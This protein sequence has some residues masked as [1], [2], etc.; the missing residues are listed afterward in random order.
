MQ[1][2]TFDQV[3]PTADGQITAQD[4]QAFTNYVLATRLGTTLSLLSCRFGGKFPNLIQTK[5]KRKTC[6]M[7]ACRTGVT[8]ICVPPGNECPRTHFPSDI[9][10][11]KQISLPYLAT[12]T[13][14][15]IFMFPRVIK[16][17]P[18]KKGVLKVVSVFIGAI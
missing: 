14:E 8:V 10:S 12:L 16:Q 4:E 7:R 9:C 11:P 6:P 17:F 13:S 3:L 2:T 1:I 5:Y 15:I 18:Q